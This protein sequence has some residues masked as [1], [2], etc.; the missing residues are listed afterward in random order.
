MT[1]NL[2]FLLKGKIDLDEAQEL[3]EKAGTLPGPTGTQRLS[4]GMATV[5]HLA[6]RRNLLQRAGVPIPQGLERLEGLM[7]EHVLTMAAQEIA[8]EKAKEADGDDEGEEGD[9]EASTEPEGNSPSIA[10]LKREQRG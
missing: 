1:D 6:N 8:E 4:L 7:L 2:D 10:Q 9:F 3:V 5:Q